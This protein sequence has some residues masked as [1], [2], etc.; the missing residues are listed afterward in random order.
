MGVTARTITFAVQIGSGGSAIARTVAETLRF[1]YYDWEV[2]SQ[3]AMAAGVSP[4]AVAAAERAPSLLERIMERLLATGAYSEDEGLSRLS[5]ATMASAI[6]TL[7]SQHYRELIEDAVSELGERG[8]AVIVGHASQVVLQDESGVL[9]VLICGSP[10]RRAQRL[11]EEEGISPDQASAAVRES[12]QE[13]RGFFKRIYGI[14]L[15]SASHYDLALN[16]DHLSTNVVTELILSAARE[17]PGL[18]QETGSA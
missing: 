15:L 3:A 4:Q 12:D 17:L 8:E 13:R 14:E 1:R 2:T 9:K 10:A 18:I 16:T 7:D 11:A 5:A 6:R